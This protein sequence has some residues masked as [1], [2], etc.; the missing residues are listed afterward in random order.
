MVSFLA[1]K[2]IGPGA[3]RTFGQFGDDARA[4]RQDEMCRM[5]AQSKC[6]G[7]FRYSA[8]TA[9]GDGEIIPRRDG[10]VQG[11]VINQ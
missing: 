5:H 8:G 9:F 6:R 11:E 4:G 3:V 2:L 10:V 1:L 7:P